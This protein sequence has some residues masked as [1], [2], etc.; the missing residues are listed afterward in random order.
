MDSEQWIVG[1]SCKLCRR[2]KY[3]KTQCKNRKNLIYTEIANEI[4]SLFLRN[5]APQTNQEKDECQK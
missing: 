3:C 4:S 1:G 2:Q 5:T